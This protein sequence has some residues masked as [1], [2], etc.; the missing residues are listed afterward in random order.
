LKSKEEAKQIGL[1]T[2]RTPLAKKKA[3]L[4]LSPLYG[5]TSICEQKEK[6]LKRKKLE[7]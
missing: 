7:L 3:S 6:S 1:W 4:F 5:K 2:L